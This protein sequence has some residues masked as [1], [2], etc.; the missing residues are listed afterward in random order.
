MSAHASYATICCFAPRPRYL[1]S[2]VRSA[3]HAEASWAVPP[4][5]RGAACC[6]SAASRFPPRCRLASA[7][8]FRPGVCTRG[9]W[10]G[11]QQSIRLMCKLSSAHFLAAPQPERSCVE[12][13]AR[14]TQAEPLQIASAKSGPRASVKTA[15]LEGGVC[16]SLL[17]RAHA[18]SGVGAAPRGAA[19]CAR[20]VSAGLVDGTAA[21]ACARGA[22][23]PLAA[24]PPGASGAQV[25]DCIGVGSPFNSAGPVERCRGEHGRRNHCR[26]WCRCSWCECNGAAVAG[27]A[28]TSGRACGAVAIVGVVAVAADGSAICGGLGG[29]TPVVAG[30]RFVN[31]LV[32]KARSSEVCVRAGE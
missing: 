4:V 10:R 1:G 18:F 29:A 12:G 30:G 21:A 31:G 3:E 17:P 32:A 24:G 23:I 11:Y 27:A 25:S 2:L 7:I 28:K 8:V 19:R 6:R 13:R 14:G 20:K 26:G 16:A 9:G 22:G 5:V 15:G